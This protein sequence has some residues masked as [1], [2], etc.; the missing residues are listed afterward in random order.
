MPRG[1]H[2]VS[3]GVKSQASTKLN[4]IVHLGT[5][6]TYNQARAARLAAEKAHYV[7]AS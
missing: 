3:G 5:F 2:R 6:D 1:R 7:V 4:R